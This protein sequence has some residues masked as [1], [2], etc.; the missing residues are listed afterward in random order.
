V[1]EI[2]NDTTKIYKDGP[3]TSK[4]TIIRP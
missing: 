4:I 1:K 3:I 2:E